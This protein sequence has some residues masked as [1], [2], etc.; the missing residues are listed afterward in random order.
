LCCLQF[1]ALKAYLS[2]GGSALFTLEEGG[3][4]RLGQSVL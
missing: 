3:E 4:N 1:E 2:S